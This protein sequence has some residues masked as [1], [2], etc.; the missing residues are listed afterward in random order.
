MS[1][2]MIYCR[3]SSKEQAASAS[4]LPCQ[5]RE[6]QQYVQINQI[7]LRPETNT[8]A[9][10][11]FVD[12][13]V[14]AYKIGLFD[15]PG[16]RKMW[17]VLERGDSIVVLCMDRMFR[18][19]LDFLR[20]WQVFAEAGINIQ[21]V[22]GDIDMSSAAGRLA[23]T[24]IAAF[25]QFKSDIISERTREGQ[26]RR[27]ERLGLGDPPKKKK[28]AGV[29][30]VN[31]DMVKVKPAPSPRPSKYDAPIHK[32]R[33]WSYLRV[34][35]T[36]QTVE[37]QR[38]TIDRLRAIMAERGYKDTGELSI[39][40]GVSAW[41]V[42]W[43][44]RPVGKKI[45][46]SCQQGDVILVSR[47]DRM[48]RSLH[49]MCNTMKELS[50]RGVLFRA[51][52]DVDTSTLGGK[53]ICAMVGIM[54]EWESAELS[55]KMKQVDKYLRSVYGPWI[56]PTRLPMWLRAKWLDDEHWVPKLKMRGLIEVL[57]V[58]SARQHMGKVKSAAF[59]ERYCATR[60]GRPVVPAYGVH[61]RP[62]VMKLIR[63]GQSHLVRP[64]NK[65]IRN[66]PDQVVGKRV[67]PRWSRMLVEKYQNSLASGTL[68][69]YIESSGMDLQSLIDMQFAHKSHA[70]VREY[71]SAIVLPEWYRSQGDPNAS[72][73]R[74]HDS[75]AL[76][77]SPVYRSEVVSDSV[78]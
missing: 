49:D 43:R 34:S 66:H 25:A 54:A 47:M 70:A 17:A 52:D 40:H 71:K 13:G 57:L 36:S 44:D 12:P 8:D 59:I 42:N 60:D 2:A 73:D 18:S 31:P 62:F 21:F 15:R 10:G 14:S 65:Y 5:V 41:S 74:V 24:T 4:S 32:G 48:F 7:K 58:N 28:K 72:P 64:F 11:V 77:S 19:S 75:E 78:E 29:R 61:H 9:P 27:K 53:L 33:I 38:E 51:G 16:F 63:E 26:R 35:T 68:R 56:D 45:F 6:C 23:A 50:D 37:S 67:L 46:E 22:S 20:S 76:C 55:R 30:V 69:S 39:E 3:V 1:R